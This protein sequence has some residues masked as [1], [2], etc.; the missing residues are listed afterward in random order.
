[1]SE[2][3]NPQVR[4]MMDAYH[5]LE[6]LPR[7]PQ[8][9]EVGGHPFQVELHERSRCAI[10]D[11]GGERCRFTEGHTVDHIFAGPRLVEIR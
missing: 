4:A 9:F 11:G 3:E 8:V 5:R 2:H 10:H 1:M 6:S 7:A